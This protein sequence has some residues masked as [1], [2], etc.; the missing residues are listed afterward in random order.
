MRSLMLL[1]AMLPGVVVSLSAQDTTTQADTILDV[2]KPTSPTKAV[3]DWNSKEAVAKRHQDA[4]R[5]QEISDSLW[6]LRTS[7]RS[8][9]SQA[10]TTGIVVYYRV[11]EQNE[12]YWR[13][14]WRL[15]LKNNSNSLVQFTAVIKFLDADG[16]D[17]AEDRVYNV[18]LG[19]GEER[20]FTGAK[21]IDVRPAG[22]VVKAR[23]EFEQ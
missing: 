17:V 2:N 15:P 14:A 21:L 20:E 19:P 22:T 7:Q 5:A 3:K 18:S 12:V 8:G 16:F 10:T 23:A 6:R 1:L 13:F 11:T 9:S 4:V